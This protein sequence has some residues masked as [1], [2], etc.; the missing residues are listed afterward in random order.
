MVDAP[1]DFIPLHIR[2]GYILPTQRPGNSTLFTLVEHL[3]LFANVLILGDLLKIG[4]LYHWQPRATNGTY[5]G[6]R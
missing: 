2:G 4:S 3:I 6:I 5:C 1:L